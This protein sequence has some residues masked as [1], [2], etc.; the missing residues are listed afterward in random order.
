MFFFC[1][2]FNRTFFENY[3]SKSIEGKQPSEGTEMKESVINLV[4][5]DENEN[6]TKENQFSIE[7]IE[8]Y[9]KYMAKLER[10]YP[11]AFENIIKES[12]KNY[13]QYSS[14][15][16]AA[17]KLAIGNNCFYIYHVLFKIKKEK[18]LYLYLSFLSWFYYRISIK[19]EQHKSRL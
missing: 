3:S 13:Q 9:E 19:F 17:I 10:Q 18:L 2:F 7:F 15:Y 5:D 14:N 16:M 8:W 4:S 6:I 11:V 12:I 1:C